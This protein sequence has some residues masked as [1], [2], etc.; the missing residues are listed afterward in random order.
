MC[1]SLAIVASPRLWTHGFAP[2]AFA[3]VCLFLLIMD[4]INKL[5]TPLITSKLIKL[6]VFNSYFQ[7]ETVPVV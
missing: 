6:R 5:H 7:Q 1:G 3:R 2:P 4:S